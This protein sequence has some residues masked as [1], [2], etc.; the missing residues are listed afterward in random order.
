MIEGI[1]HITYVVSNLDRAAD[2]FKY[3]FDAEEVYSSGDEIHS[4]SREKFFL[5]NGIWIAL[6]QGDPSLEKTYDHVAFK[7]PSTDQEM[8]LERIN[9]LGLEIK[10]DRDRIPGE[11]V[12]IYFYDYDDHLFELHAGSLGERLVTYLSALFHKYGDAP[13]TSV[14]HARK[15][16]D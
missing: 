2:M 16:R 5:I 9:N 6:M 15:A 11:G 4:Y 7:I 8:Y 3:I 12:S 14:R 1:S 10:T 13:S